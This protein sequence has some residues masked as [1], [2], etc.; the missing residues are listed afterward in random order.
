M[1]A[2][3]GSVASAP[4]KVI[5][6]GEHA[7]VYGHPG[8][9]LPLPHCRAEAELIGMPGSEHFLIEADDLGQSY[10]GDDP[11]PKG[12]GRALVAA[13]RELHRVRPRLPLAGWRLRIRSA[14]PIARGLGSGAAVSVAIL[15]A[16]ARGFSL[17]LSADELVALAFELEKIHHGRPSGI[18]N[19]VIALERPLWFV[20]GAPPEVLETPHPLLVVGD[21]GAAPSTQEVVAAVAER[22]RRDPEAI[23][24]LFAEIA[25]LTREGLAVLQAGDWPRLGRLMSRNHELLRRLGVSSERLDALVRAALAAGALGAKLTGAGRGGCM[26]ALAPDSTTADAIRRSLLEAGAAGVH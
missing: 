25:A 22:R 24:G 5:L 19:T 16:L 23:D 13:V 6:F 26:I 10:R 14:I 1:P 9:A 15:R 21:S 7:V 8:I 4:G 2:Q 12:P 18:D 20:K 3:R 17:D 11:P